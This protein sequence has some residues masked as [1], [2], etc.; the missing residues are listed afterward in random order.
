MLLIKLRAIERQA[1]ERRRID[2]AVAAVLAGVETIRRDWP[3]ETG[4]DTLTDTG[5]AVEVHARAHLRLLSTQQPTVVQGGRRESQAPVP[6][7]A[8]IRS[9]HSRSRWH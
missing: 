1:E 5:T 9:R 4:P 7:S 3:P 8:E 2:T 6:H